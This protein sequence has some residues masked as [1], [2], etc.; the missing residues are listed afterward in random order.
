M[1]Q[2]LK[3]SEFSS[4]EGQVGLAKAG[5]CIGALTTEQALAYEQIAR[6]D[7]LLS[8]NSSVQKM[9]RVSIDQNQGF[10]NIEIIKPAVDQAAPAEAQS[11]ART[12]K[13]REKR[14]PIE[15]SLLQILKLCVE[16]DNRNLFF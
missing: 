11:S 8:T 16:N 4:R 12:T 13:T 9:Q 2:S 15:L 1:R 14:L 5:M 6:Q 3:N 7:Y 10:A